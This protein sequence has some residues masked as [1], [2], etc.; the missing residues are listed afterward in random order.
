[1]RLI[2]G[3]PHFPGLFAAA[4]GPPLLC[5]L[6]MRAHP[7]KAEE[8]FSQRDVRSPV[9]DDNDSGCGRWGGAGDAGRRRRRSGSAESI[10]LSRNSGGG[11]C[12]EQVKALIH[13][14]TH[15]DEDQRERERDRD[16][17]LRC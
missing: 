3:G 9:N 7:S 6:L 5:A 11:R 1:M 15:R 16:A 8:A 4:A 10:M 2:L 14:R 17:S 13:V 12:W